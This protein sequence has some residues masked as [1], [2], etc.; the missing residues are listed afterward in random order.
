MEQIEVEPNLPITNVCE[1]MIYLRKLYKLSQGQVADGLTSSG[2]KPIGR[3]AVSHLETGELVPSSSML[4]ALA[5][6]YGVSV[7][8]IERGI[9]KTPTLLIPNGNS[10]VPVAN[11][12]KK[13][14]SR[15][16]FVQSMKYREKLRKFRPA[17]NRIKQ[18][19]LE[20]GLKQ[21]EV[22]ILLGGKGDGS[23]L[24]KI[25]LNRQVPTTRWLER[26]CAALDTDMNYI[27][28]GKKKKATDSSTLLFT[29]ENEE[30]QQNLENNVI[31]EPSIEFNE[32]SSNYAAKPIVKNTLVDSENA[33]EWPEEVFTRAEIKNGDTQI[34]EA[35]G[36]LTKGNEVEFD[37]RKH[38]QNF[39]Q[40]TC[41]KLNLTPA[42]VASLFE[43]FTSK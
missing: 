28:T 29:V 18:I 34:R 27:L 4:L 11:S 2:I 13:P 39:V 15:E 26:F 8:W 21:E 42:E 25:E 19:R 30:P 9:G 14:Y 31:E 37:L 5:Q 12:E 17:A 3:S 7:G 40:D 33:P 1:R 16:Y 20:A 41:Q 38:F 23:H 35:T 24:S 10:Q 36:T 43:F 6:F 32:I 22:S